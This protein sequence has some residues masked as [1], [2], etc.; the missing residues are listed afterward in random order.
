MHCV[1]L[2]IQS[3]C[4]QRRVRSSP[5]VQGCE[6]PRV[7]DRRLSGVWGTER[8]E[9]YHSPDAL[10]VSPIEFHENKPKGNLFFA[11]HLF[12]SSCKRLIHQPGDDCEGRN[13]VGFPF[14]LS[15]L[16]LSSPFGQSSLSSKQHWV[17][18]L[19]LLATDAWHSKGR[20]EACLL[21]PS[22]WVHRF[23]EAAISPLNPCF[24]SL[25]RRVQTRGFFF[26]C[27]NGCQPE[28]P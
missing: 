19:F 14:L 25:S 9:G 10:G 26:W 22:L 7:W 4:G 2:N 16:E 23:S 17:E 1:M 24:P 15:F 5:G 20:A 28:V 13:A 11:F 6:Q 18:S 3:L 27:S 21:P 8:P 12:F